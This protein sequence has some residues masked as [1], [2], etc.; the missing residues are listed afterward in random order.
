M[1]SISRVDISSPDRIGSFVAVGPSVHIY[2]L[3]VTN[4]ILLI[5]YSVHIFVFSSLSLS[6]VPLT[7]VILSHSVD[8]DLRDRIFLI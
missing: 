6:S 2:V 8:H 1:V 5:L 7:D 4:T 3:K